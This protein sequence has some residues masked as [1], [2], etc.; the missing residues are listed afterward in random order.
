MNAV[1]TGVAAKGVVA[2][3]ACTVGFGPLVACAPKKKR[4]PNARWPL[5]LT[6]DARLGPSVEGTVIKTH[7]AGKSRPMLAIIGGIHGNEAESVEP[8]R[9]VI[10]WHHWNPPAD[11]LV[12]AVVNMNPDGIEAGTRGNARGVDLNRNWPASNFEPSAAHGPEPLSEPESAEVHG[13]LEEWKPEVVIVLHS[14]RSGPFVNFDGPAEHYAEVFTAAAT[15]VDPEAGW[16]VKPDM[17]YATPGSFGSY[18]GKDLGVPTLTVEFKRGCSEEDAERVLKA[19]VAAVMDAMRAQFAE[20]VALR[21]DD[22][23]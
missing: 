13:W 7:I 20:G 12:G 23:S 11:M 18:Y 16:H 8:L 5:N 22:G 3:L 2:L 6:R 10:W 1:M 14:I 15:G 4:L 17:G 21:I 9:D 19:G